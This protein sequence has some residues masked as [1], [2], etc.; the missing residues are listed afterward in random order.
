MSSTIQINVSPSPN[1]SSNPQSGSFWNFIS[2]IY[3]E[4]KK[5]INLFF[6]NVI[7][8]F[9]GSYKQNNLLS[10]NNKEKQKENK[11]ME[12][13][14]NYQDSDDE[15]NQIFMIE[16]QSLSTS[17]PISSGFLE[18]KPYKKF[19][20]ILVFDVETTGLIPTGEKVRK[21]IPYINQMPFILQL[22]FIQYDILESNIIKKYDSYIN[23]HPL[24]Q[25][26]PFITELTGITREKC[27]SGV[28][29]IEGLTEFYKAYMESDCVI[30]HNIK[31]DS[32]IILYEIERHFHSLVQQCPHI[33]SLFD[34][35]FNRV[36]DIFNCCTMKTSI[37]VCN[38]MVSRKTNPEKKYKKYPQLKE[39]YYTLFQKEP[40]NLHN[41]IVDVLY[42]LRCFL[43]MR[44][45]HEIHDEKFDYYLK[46]CL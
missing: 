33:L 36:M 43:R 14:Q 17:P 40:E 27:D 39:L 3:K 1:N 29:I 15:N 23:I 4:N 19:R 32:T 8:Y 12:F 18:N 22:S 10:Y 46:S 35:R 2:L 16:S 24:I 25:I 31:F 37:D 21:D 5:Q 34:I 42:T 30:A 6:V 7:K 9:F 28:S 45:H 41:S 44:I 20:K 26:E 13:I 11:P 38:I